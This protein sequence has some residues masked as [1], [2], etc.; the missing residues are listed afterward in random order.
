[1]IETLAA[2]IFWGCY[3]A[4]GTDYHRS[5]LP[6]KPRWS[7]R[8]DPDDVAPREHIPAEGFSAHSLGAPEQP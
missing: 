7:S 3:V 1:M 2:L 6:S 4:F 5:I 8:R